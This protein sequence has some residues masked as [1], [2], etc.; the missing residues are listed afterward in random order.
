MHKLLKHRGGIFW[1]VETHG[2]GGGGRK[3]PLDLREEQATAAS[4][5]PDGDRLNAHSDLRTAVMESDGMRD[6][7]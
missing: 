3:T 1:H 5:N 4:Q 7:K 2:D 6:R